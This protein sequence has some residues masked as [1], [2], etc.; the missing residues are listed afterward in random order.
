MSVARTFWTC[1]VCMAV[2]R[3]S[4]DFEVVKVDGV[5]YT[6]CLDSCAKYVNDNEC[7]DTCPTGTF[8][9]EDGATCK[10]TCADKKYKTETLTD[11]KTHN[12]CMATADTCDY[13]VEEEFEIDTEK[14]TY[15]KCL[16]VCSAKTYL[17][18]K[19]C[20]SACPLDK[21]THGTDNTCRACNADDDAGIYWNQIIS[22]CVE[23]CPEGSNLPDSE[24]ICG[25]CEHYF[26]EANNK[27]V[28][29]CELGADADGR[30]CNQ[31]AECG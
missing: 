19:K 30:V 23:A 29:E 22:K 14:K 16:E 6:H 12:V 11:G 28:D 10:E 7:V 15:T 3:C 18:D 5:Y 20:V 27:C 13:S 21:P 1:N 24:T 2:D 31:A 4:N 17:N 26:D 25:A 8:L 9:Q